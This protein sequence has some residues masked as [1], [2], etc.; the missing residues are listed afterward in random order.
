VEE[1]K[2]KNLASQIKLNDEKEHFLRL[3]ASE[4]QESMNE[5]HRHSIER[6]KGVRYSKGEMDKIDYIFKMIKRG[7][8]K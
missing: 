3:K 2:E 6:I 1:L 5:I 8:R 7:E 4:L